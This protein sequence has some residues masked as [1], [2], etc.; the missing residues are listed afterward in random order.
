VQCSYD[1][2][3]RVFAPS[4]WKHLFRKMREWICLLGT[5][6]RNYHVECRVYTPNS[7]LNSSPTSSIYVPSVFEHTREEGALLA[8]RTNIGRP[9]TSTERHKKHAG[10]KSTF[11]NSAAVGQFPPEPHAAAFAKVN[12]LRMLDRSTKL[13]HCKIVSPNY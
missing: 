5:M 12:P 13:P 10:G 2:L 6:C 3:R 1:P 8:S 9:F 11:N 4:D 7:E